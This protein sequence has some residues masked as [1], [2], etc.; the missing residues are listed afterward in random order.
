VLLAAPSIKNF[1]P[2]KIRFSLPFSSISFHFQKS[3][4]KFGEQPQAHAQKKV[5]SA[6]HAVIICDP[7]ALFL[8]GR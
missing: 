6:T 3:K 2:L 1:A 5:T 7:D 4:Q 8:C